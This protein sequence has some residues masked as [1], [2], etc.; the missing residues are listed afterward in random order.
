MPYAYGQNLAQFCDEQKRRALEKTRQVE[1]E[2]RRAAATE[3]Q[4]K[5]PCRAT[6]L[7]SSE[8]SDQN[9]SS[10]REAP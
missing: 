9:I 10:I 8:L 3:S 2:G 6:A 5:E 4:G 7:C 1:R